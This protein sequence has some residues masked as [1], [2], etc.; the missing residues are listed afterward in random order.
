M[1][2]TRDTDLL[3]C[4][5]GDGGLCPAGEGLRLDQSRATGMA[6]RDQLRAWLLSIRGVRPFQRRLWHVV[7]RPALAE[8]GKIERTLPTGRRIQIFAEG[9][10]A[11]YA[12][13]ER[14]PV[15]GPDYYLTYIDA[16]ALWRDKEISVSPACDRI[17]LKEGA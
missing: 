6:F 11:D 8:K 16:E 7:I 3:L 14:G 9:V 4:V 1:P 15:Y 10:A 12:R 17:E 13:E 5:P 2:T